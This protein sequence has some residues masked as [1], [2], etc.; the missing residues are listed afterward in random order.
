MLKIKNGGL[1]QC[2]KVYALT[3]SAVKG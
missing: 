1:V 3:G 2:G